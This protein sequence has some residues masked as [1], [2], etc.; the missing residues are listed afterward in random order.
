[1]HGSWRPQTQFAT[2][3]LPFQ[4]DALIDIHQSLGDSGFLN[5]GGAFSGQRN[6]NFKKSP[7]AGNQ[8]IK[9]F[10]FLNVTT[11]SP[12]PIFSAYDL[13]LQLNK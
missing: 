1:M 6:I 11:T 10:A 3:P 7:P 4:K 2:W 13:L 9:Y 5:T 8:D 12:S